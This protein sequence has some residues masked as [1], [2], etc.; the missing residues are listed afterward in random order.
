M[1]PHHS[2]AGKKML[3]PTLRSKMT[4]IFVDE[5]YKHKDIAPIVQINLSS[6]FDSE[7]INRISHFYLEIKKQIRELKIHYGTKRPSIGLRNLVRALKYVDSALT[8]KE[9]TFAPSRALYEALV[10]NFTTQ[11]DQESKLIIM[12]M[13]DEIVFASDPPNK[14]KMGSYKFSNSANRDN[15][16]IFENYAIKKGKFNPIKLGADL[17]WEEKFI[18]T[19]TFKKLVKTFASII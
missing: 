6:L 3:N 18:M 15:Y 2:S 13:I 12:K 9:V 7:Y 16:E 19:S 4:E 17:D 1:N 10:L 11:V 8:N 5:L 14:E